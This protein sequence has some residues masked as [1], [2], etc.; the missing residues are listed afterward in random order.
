MPH[1]TG[2]AQSPVPVIRTASIARLLPYYR[3]VLGFR[4]VQHIP[5]VVA[6]LELGGV[7]LQLWQRNDCE[8]HSFCVVSL[9]AR[10]SDIFRLYAGFARTAPTALMEPRP[11]LQPWNSWEFG[12]VDNE[13]NQLVFE[14]WVTRDRVAAPQAGRAAG[15]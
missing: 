7:A 8:G 2:S 3:D 1:R 5:G 6:V 11:Q 13:G 4:P 15:H 12:V 9:D 10:Q 14:Q